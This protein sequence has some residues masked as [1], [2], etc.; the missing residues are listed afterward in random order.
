MHHLQVISVDGNRTPRAVNLDGRYLLVTGYSRPISGLV[1]PEK[2][3]THQ[4]FAAQCLALIQHKET[5]SIVSNLGVHLPCTT[6]TNTVAV[7]M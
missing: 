3:A 7:G 2:V 1:R 6:T 4:R 5:A